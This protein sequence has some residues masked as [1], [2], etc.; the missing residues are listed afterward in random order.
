MS[1]VWAVPVTGIRE[2]QIFRFLKD[3]GCSVRV[4]EVRLFKT[5]RQFDRAPNTYFD[6]PEA[7]TPFAK[8]LLIAGTLWNRRITKRQQKSRLRLGALGGFSLPSG[9]AGIRTHQHLP[10]PSACKR[11]EDFLRSS[12]RALREL[13]QTRFQR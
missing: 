10:H 12:S 11:T 8:A 7:R 3:A 1:T 6:I 5:G 2:T 9:L 13:H 4:V